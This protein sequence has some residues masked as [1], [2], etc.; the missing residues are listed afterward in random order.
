MRFEERRFRA[1]L[2]SSEATMETIEARDS[3]ERSSEPKQSTRAWA[4]K[5]SQALSWSWPSKAKAE[6]LAASCAASIARPLAASRRT[7]LALAGMMVEPY[8]SSGCRSS[9]IAEEP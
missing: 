9:P 4:R 3:S 1:I 7:G 6:T 5:G 8:C 2:P